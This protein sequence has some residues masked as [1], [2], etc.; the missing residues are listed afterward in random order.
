MARTRV[1][2]VIAGEADQ[3]PDARQGWLH[4]N[5]SG[6]GT[7]HFSADG[8][9]ASSI[10][11]G[12]RAQRATRENRRCGKRSVNP[13]RTGPLADH[14]GVSTRGAP[15]PEGGHSSMSTIPPQEV[16][17]MKLETATKIKY[18]GRGL[19]RGAVIAMIIDSAWSGPPAQPNAESHTAICVTQFIRAPNHEATLKEFGLG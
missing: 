1:F 16:L 11:G 9:G 12:P 5:S 7:G 10:V 6:V 2:G 18:G 3:L 8:Y 13:S 19:I 17:S 14:A 4:G 15:R